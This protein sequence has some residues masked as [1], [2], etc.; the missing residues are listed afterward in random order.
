DEIRLAP[1]VGL[2]RALAAGHDA[3]TA[4]AAAPKEGAQ[5]DVARLWKAQFDLIQM[6]LPE[7]KRTL[8]SFPAPS[9]IPLVEILRARLALVENRPEG[10]VIAYQNAINAGP[11]RD[12]LWR[13]MSMAF[14]AGG[15]EDLAKK[16]LTRLMDIGTRDPDVYYVKAALSKTADEL[17][18]ELKKAW[19]LQ[20]A[21]R[22]DL[23][24]S[25]LLWSVVRNRNPFVN[26][27]DP[28]EPRFASTNTGSRAIT[29][30]A[31]AKGRVSGDFFHI[32]VNDS[33]ISIPGG[34]PLAPMD[35]PFVGADEWERLEEERALADV[36]QL[37]MS[38]PT[39]GSY[40]QPAMRA[41]ITNA[42][43]A[44]AEHNRW[45]DILTLT[46]AI[47]PKSEFVPPAL[48][49]QRA[50]ALQRMRRTSEAR[51]LL[52]ELAASP[53]LARKRDSNALEELAEKLASFDDFEAAIKIVERAR[54]INPNPYHEWRISQLLM[55]IKLAKQ[56]STH[57]TQNFRIQYPQELPSG[58]ATRLGVVLEGELKRLQSWIPVQSFQPVVVN[59]VWWQDFTSI[60]TGSEDV[61][62]FYN[63]KITVPLAGIMDFVP[64]IVAIVT[65]E[66]AHA[67]IAQA[68]N[69]QAP[70]WFHE[71]LAQR[72]SMV[73]YHSNAFNMY[74]DSKLFAISVLEPMFLS[75]RDPDMIGAAYIMSQ[76]LI[77]FIEERYGR[78]GVHKLLESY[79]GG[80]TAHDALVALA[81]KDLSQFNADFRAWGKAENR[82]F[83]N[84]I[85][86]RYDI[87]ESDTMDIPSMD[88]SPRPNRPRQRVGG[89]TFYQDPRVKP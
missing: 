59:V 43:D 88:G 47:S 16:N 5:G 3:G 39:A 48:F 19:N 61:L 41:R 35:A 44:L 71:G 79:N 73:E 13:E 45:P 87:Q 60:Y 46:A 64:E 84:Q 18:T 69:D 51:A 11:G 29:L 33:Q 65:H 17:E 81:G 68:T 52:I 55:D 10:A 32:T 54:A 36:P 63:G 6:K 20:P 28:Q 50:E 82:V 74:D 58:L 38:P 77:R 21:S 62:G 27:S 14:I 2:R 80:G 30:P 15:F 49:F 66:L 23:V 22:D 67:M 12:A 42:V 31:G 75:S 24:M 78:A 37:L 56:Y 7:V 86:V 83:E 1:L 89:G 9:D 85:A 53:V 40:M 26:L 76:T 4:V 57:A 34:A 25:G 8:D 72:V 70:R